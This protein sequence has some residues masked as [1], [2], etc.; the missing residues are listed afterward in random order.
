[1]KNVNCLSVQHMPY[2]ETMR[3]LHLFALTFWLLGGFVAIADNMTRWRYLLLSTK[4]VL[5]SH[6]M[7]LSD[8][9]FC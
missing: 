6:V 3:N 2:W 9:I 4:Q 5:L 7:D 8:L 1:M